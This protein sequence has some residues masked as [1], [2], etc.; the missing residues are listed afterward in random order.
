M[1]LCKGK[2]I[3]GLPC[4]NPSKVNNDFCHLHT[5]QTN[6]IKHPKQIITAEKLASQFKT[7]TDRNPRD[8]INTPW[9]EL[10]E[11]YY[12]LTGKYSTEYDSCDVCGNAVKE[13]N[14]LK[15]KYRKVPNDF[16]IKLSNNCIYCADDKFNKY[17][18]KQISKQDVQIALDRAEKYK[19]IL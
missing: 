15:G 2:T 16:L 18:N 10:E 8:D 17:K 9:D 13:V 4:K 5:N 1:L 11:R 3:K 6:P 12:K 19:N 7:L 14:R